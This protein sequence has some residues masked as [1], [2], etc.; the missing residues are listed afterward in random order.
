[1]IEGMHIVLAKDTL[2]YIGLL[3]GVLVFAVVSNAFGLV[4][5]PGF[6]DEF[7]EATNAT[8]LNFLIVE[9]E[10]LSTELFAWDNKTTTLGPD[11]LPDKMTELAGY[12]NAL[13]LTGANG[14]QE[15]LDKVPTW[16]L[17]AA[18]AQQQQQQQQPVIS[19]QAQNKETPTMILEEVIQDLRNGTSRVD[20]LNDCILTMESM[21]YLQCLSKVTDNETVMDF[22]RTMI[23]DL[24]SEIYEQKNPVEEKNCMYDAFNG[25]IP[26]TD[27]FAPITI[28]EKP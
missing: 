26:D 13:A 15:I 12:A 3:V 18:T 21:E 10:D 6:E 24:C 14:V 25:N 28:L 4:L 23:A 2:L 8:G 7:S 5:I 20:Q 17:T 9:H 27:L 11:G 1:M 22:R 19:I 16:N